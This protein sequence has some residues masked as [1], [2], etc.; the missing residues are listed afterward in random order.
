MIHLSDN[1]GAQEAINERRRREL[2]VW[3]DKHKDEIA[4]AAAKAAEEAAKHPA[5]ETNNEI[6][7]NASPAKTAPEAETKTEEIKTEDAAKAD[8]KATIN[9]NDKEKKNGN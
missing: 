1:H 2:Q 3:N 7:S 8:D 5:V 6:G 9:V 4:A